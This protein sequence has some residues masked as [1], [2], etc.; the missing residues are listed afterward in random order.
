MSF[1]TSVNP[2]CW[3]T[4]PIY[5][6]SNRHLAA[7]RN[8]HYFYD[9]GCLTVQSNLDFHGVFCTVL[10][11]TRTKGYSSSKLAVSS[12]YII[13]HLGDLLYGDSIV[14]VPRQI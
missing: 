14:R 3:K 2:R 5:I 9:L 8:N 12:V 11:L 7:A 1:M 10:E 4:L 6:S 13:I